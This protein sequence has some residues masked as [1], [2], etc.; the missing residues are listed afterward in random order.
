MKIINVLMII[1][2]FLTP[3]YAKKRIYRKTGDVNIYI[4]YDQMIKNHELIKNQKLLKAMEKDYRKKNI[5]TFFA[6][7]GIGGVLGAFATVC[8][9]YIPKR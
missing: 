5:K 3:L 1:I 8:I 4:N 7:L 2:L 6:G 9:I